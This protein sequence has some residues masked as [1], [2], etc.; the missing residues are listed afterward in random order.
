MKKILHTTVKKIKNNSDVYK[1][2]QI[3]SEFLLVEDGISKNKDIVD[4]VR[5]TIKKKAELAIISKI[6][7]TD[8]LYD[9][10]INMYS[11]S[12]PFKKKLSEILMY[13]ALSQKGITIKE[14]IQLTR[15]SEQ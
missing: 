15:F 13:F 4:F 11:E 7:T 14:I 1:F 6:T 3:Y 10:I 9:F 2:L 5:E 12:V 8:G